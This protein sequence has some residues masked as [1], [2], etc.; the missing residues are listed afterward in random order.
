[1]REGEAVALLAAGLEDDADR[2][3][4]ERELH[5]L[6]RRLGE[7]PLLL[8]L[9]NSALRHS[10]EHENQPL[11]AALKWV[12]R[13]LTKRGL[14]YFDSGSKEER[15]KA[16]A[17]TIGVSLDL[18]KNGERERYHELA[19]FPED[20]EIPLATLEKFW[21]RT[22]GLDEFD[23]EDLCKRL[24]RF[25]LLWSF[26]ATARRV[27]LHDVV[28]SYLIEQQPTKMA[29]LHR[30]LLD[31]HRPAINPAT[32]GAGGSGW[33]AMA[34]D[35]PYLW[36][37]LAFH[38]V[39]G[40][41]G[42]E[43]VEAVKDWRYLVTKIW[44]RK[45]LAVEAD[46][47]AAECFVSDDDPL[48]VLRRNFVNSG[49]LLSHGADPDG[50]RAT[51][52]SR[53][54]H[55]DELKSLTRQLHELLS[56]PCVVPEFRLPDLPHPALIRTLEGHTAWVSGCA[57]SGDGALIVSASDDGTLRV[58]D[59]HS[60]QCL[61]VFY[62]DGPIYCCAM[63]AETGLIVAGGARGVYFLKLWR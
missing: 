2:Q 16:V 36:D 38:L 25:S 28:R 29:E 4:V 51:L 3:Q 52:Y 44:K 53:L 13:A 55:L 47:L 45:A 40:E 15:N 46:L 33:A 37:Y 43:L 39:G 5:K 50:V 48:R 26:D 27:R 9:V 12:N 49:H 18:L 54:Q 56:R 1:M 6:A 20:A 19:V 34:E 8:K 11:P 30:Q 17:Q 62:A 7:W 59:G 24:N 21:G 58:W 31:A 61:A 35:E 57:V 42:A 60:G 63:H 23:T 22:G 32:G 10:R 41:R 14:T